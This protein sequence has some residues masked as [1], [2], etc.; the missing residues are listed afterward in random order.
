MIWYA[1]CLLLRCLVNCYLSLFNKKRQTR[2]H[3]ST[4]LQH[5]ATAL[6]AFPHHAPIHSHRTVFHMIKDSK[7]NSN[8][9]HSQRNN[10]MLH[11]SHPL[12]PIHSRSDLTKKKKIGGI[13]RPPNHHRKKNKNQ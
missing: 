5:T 13:E 2:S 8:K 4:T 11:V 10:Y 1:A 9:N 12:D 3:K 6:G 7:R